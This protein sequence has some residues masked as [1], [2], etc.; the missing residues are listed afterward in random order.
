MLPTMLSSTSD[1]EV[2]IVSSEQSGVFK[3][4]TS[5][6]SHDENFS[7]YAHTVAST[8]SWILVTMETEFPVTRVVVVNR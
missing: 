1:T 8:D 5:D 7:S 6:L 2:P 4:F 3:D